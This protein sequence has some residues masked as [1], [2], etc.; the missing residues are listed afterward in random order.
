[1]DINEDLVLSAI[2]GALREEKTPI[3]K[4]LVKAMLAALASLA[5]FGVPYLFSYRDQL[6]SIW[7]IAFVLWSIYFFV[8]FSL[9]FYPQPRLMVRGVWSPF[10]VAK[11]L[12]I[13][14]VSTFLQIILCPSFVFLDSPLN[15]NPLTPITEQL[16]HYGGMNLCM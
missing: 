7:I 9:F 3:A 6:N 5:L 16:M 8:G 4:R 13:S 1:M 12:L 15:W 10:V 11:L 14:T 2:Q